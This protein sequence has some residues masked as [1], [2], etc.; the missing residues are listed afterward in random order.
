ME[1]RGRSLYQVNALDASELISRLKLRAIKKL[2]LYNLKYRGNEA[3]AAA[4]HTP[5]ILLMLM[6]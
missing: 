1:N 5:G 4:I 2:I 6:N 3:M